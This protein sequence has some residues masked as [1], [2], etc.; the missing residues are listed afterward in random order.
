VDTAPQRQANFVYQFTPEFVVSRFAAGATVIGT[1]DSFSGQTT[2]NGSRLMQ[3]GYVQ[4]NL[5]ARYDITDRFR[6]S[7]NVNNVLDT[8]G[9]T[10]VDSGPNASGVA[11]ARSITGRSSRALLQYSF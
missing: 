8:I 6:F 1:T 7:V 5:F 11:T 9:I 2:L 10:E 3:P 4:V